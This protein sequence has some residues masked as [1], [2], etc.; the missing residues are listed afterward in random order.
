MNREEIYR[1]IL[2]TIN[3]KDNKKLSYG[4]IRIENI[5]LKQALLDIKEYV[6]ELETEEYGNQ[7][8]SIGSGEQIYILNIINEALGSEKEWNYGLEAKTKKD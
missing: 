1:G 6:K 5:K 8:Y 4:E 7:L 3:K 2:I